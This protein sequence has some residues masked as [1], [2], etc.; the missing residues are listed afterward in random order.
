MIANAVTARHD[1]QFHPET[2]CQTIEQAQTPRE[3]RVAK[4]KHK[5]ERD[6]MTS[7]NDT[8]TFRYIKFGITKMEA[9]FTTQP[10]RPR[11]DVKS[12][13]T[14]AMMQEIPISPT[15][16]MNLRSANCSEQQAPATRTTWRVKTGD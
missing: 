9:V 12:V 14:V 16:R 15:R 10:R 2:V 11:N 1:L 13:T 8:R 3:P 6:A 5:R 7:A 4:H